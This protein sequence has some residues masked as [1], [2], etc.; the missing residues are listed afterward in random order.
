M[1]CF[2]ARYSDAGAPLCAS[3]GTI[4]APMSTLFQ[5]PPYDPAREQRRKR[6]AVIVVVTAVLAVVIF[7]RFRN[8]PYE[9]VVSN[10]F[11]ALESQDF[12]KAYGIWMHDPD[13]KQHPDRY[14]NYRF[15]E[16]HRDWGP[17]GEWG[18]IKE[19][20][21]DGCARPKNGSGV[22]VQVTVNRRTGDKARIWVEKKDKTLTFSPY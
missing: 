10:F 7:F 11:Q 20:Q 19:F 8:W 5:A 14:K 13:W 4:P 22:I 15:G 21:I 9:H 2:S 17:G 16:F 3:V 6:V 1:L 12:E 18:L